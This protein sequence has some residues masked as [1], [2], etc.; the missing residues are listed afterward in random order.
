VK[1]ADRL[2]NMQ[3]LDGHGKLEKQQTIARETMDVFVPIANRLGLTRIKSALED[4]C[5]RYLDPPAY[6]DVDVYLRETQADRDR[7]TERI[8]RALQEQIEAQGVPCEV[9]GRAKHRYSIYKKMIE[10]GLKVAEV[11]DLL[12]FRVLVA[13]V[14]QCYHVYHVLGLVHATFP[15]VPDRIKD[16]IA[17]P[18]PNGYQSLHTTVIGP[19]HRRVEVQIRTHEMHRIAEEGIAAHWR[20]KEG[21]LTPHAVAGR[22]RANL[23]DPRPVRDGAR[24]RERHGL[25]GDREGRVLRGRGVHLH[26][27]R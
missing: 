5:F 11:P 17:R 9:F 7:Y 20:Y 15:P 26:P 27:R 2:H 25:H 21:R 22:R 6:D 3:T 19:E 1:L 23:E 4:L 10:Q 16:Y 24:D 14:G 13:D 12:A 18:K 8:A